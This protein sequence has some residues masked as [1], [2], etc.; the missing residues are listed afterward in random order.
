MVVRRALLPS[1]VLEWRKLQLDPL[2]RMLTRVGHVAPTNSGHEP[3][4]LSGWLGPVAEVGL[5]PVAVRADCNGCVAHHLCVLG[6][7]SV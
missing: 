2:G 1:D 3:G 5:V 4:G 6:Q 7:T